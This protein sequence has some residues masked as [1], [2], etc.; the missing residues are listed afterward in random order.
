MSA[1]GESGLC[2]VIATCAGRS[3][4]RRAGGRD[5]GAAAAGPGAWRGANRRRFAWVLLGVKIAGR[6]ER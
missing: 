1:A 4:H 2:I 5:R 3:A 6:R